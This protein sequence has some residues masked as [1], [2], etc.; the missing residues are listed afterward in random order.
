VVPVPRAGRALAAVIDAHGDGHTLPQ[1]LCEVCATDLAVSGAG[2]ALVTEDG[3]QGVVAATD[4]VAAT[5]EDLQ[6]SLGQGPGVDASRHGRPVLQPDLRCAG[7][8]WPGFVPDALAGG[9]AAVFAF[10]LQLGGVRLGALDL[11]RDDAGSLDTHELGEALTFAE[12][13]TTVLLCLQLE[14]GTGGLHPQ[15]SESLAGSRFEVNVA[16]GMVSAQLDVDLADALVVLRAHA[17]AAERLVSDVAR[18]VVARRLR[19]DAADGARW[20]GER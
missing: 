1:A 7:A 10:P 9:V 15:Q 19:F 18:D 11:Y 20:Q 16:T 4:G 17:Y 6:F 13:A 8:R 5:T 12:T 2:L 14:T 3:H